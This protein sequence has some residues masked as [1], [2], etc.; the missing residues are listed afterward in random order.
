MSRDMIFPTMWYVRPAKA[1]ISLRICAVWSEPLLVAWIFYDCS[2]TDRTS[3]R[4]SKL[5]R[6]LHMFVWVYSCQN[7][8]LFKISCRGSYRNSVAQR[9][10]V[11]HSESSIQCSPF[12][13]LCSGC[14]GMD[15]Y[16]WI[17]LYKGTILQNN[18][19]KM[20]ISWS[21]SYNSFVK[22]SKKVRSCKHLLV[23]QN[24]VITRCVI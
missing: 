15:C 3:F 6:R 23:I 11:F 22:F 8:T 13:M 12:I 10:G 9:M 4:V 14:I 17:M 2:A 19:R 21:F 20:T 18:Y 5:K 24:H 7:A 1:Q 16:T